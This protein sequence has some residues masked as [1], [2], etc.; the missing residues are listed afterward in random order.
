MN[1][2]DQLIRMANSIANFFEALPDRE[3]GLHS[4]ADHI[5]KFWEPRMR[6]AI[7]DFLAEHPDGRTQEAELSEVA[8]QAITENRE[9]LTPK[10]A[11]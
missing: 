10:V 8:K 7:L 3:E 1:N 2:I 6:T 5:K 11:S 9:M 4:I